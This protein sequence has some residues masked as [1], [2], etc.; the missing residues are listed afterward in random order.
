MTRSRDV[1]DTQ[2]N[3]GGAVAPFVAGKNRLINADFFVNQRQFTSITTSGVYCY[4]RW[5]TQVNGDGTVTFTP[6]VFT[7]NEL[8]VSGYGQANNYLRIQTSGQTNSTSRAS[9]QQNIESVTTLAGTTVTFSFWARAATGTPSVALELRQNFAG[10]PT[11]DYP[12]GKVT[13]SNSWVRY[14]LTTTLN[15]LSGKTYASTGFVTAGLWFSAGADFAT[16]ASSVGIQNNTFDVWGLQ[17]EAGNVA[18]PFTTASGNIA[19]ELALCQRYYENNYSGGLAPGGVVIATDSIH[20][21]GAS[22]NQVPVTGT[23]GANRG[24]SVPMPYKQSKRVL[25]TLRIWDLEG[26]INK[27]TAANSDGSFI[28]NNNS[29][30]VFG[31]AANNSQFAFAW[32]STAASATHI[33]LGVM[34]EASAEL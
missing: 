22:I 2:D 31:A 5:Q 28:S 1:A 9:F 6:Q 13:I 10:S 20:S 25:P 33:Y 30:D 18:T 15:N 14:S 21:I 8:T 12:L 11:Q 19:G 24:R 3:L 4:D 7:A 32:Q 27:Y 23:A 17:L 26:N 34:W 29:L 16:R